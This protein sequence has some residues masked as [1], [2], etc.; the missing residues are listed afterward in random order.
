LR[1]SRYAAAA[2]REVAAQVSRYR[3]IDRTLA[4]R[5][6]DAVD[7]AVQ[8]VCEMPFAGSVW[9]GDVRR[10]TLGKP[11]RASVF[12]AVENDEIYVLAVW[13]DR[14]DPAALLKRLAKSGQGGVR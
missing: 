10:R 2:E 14:R 13:P 12:Y 1:G 5:Y 8:L 7:A 4:L 11:F 3:G 6:L 9:F